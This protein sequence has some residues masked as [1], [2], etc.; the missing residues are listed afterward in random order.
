MRVKVEQMQNKGHWRQFLLLDIDL[1]RVLQTPD[2]SF[3]PVM[4]ESNILMYIHIWL[5]KY[6]NQCDNTH[7]SLLCINQY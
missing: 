2:E 1:T 6:T 3:Q 5:D 4:A 7:K